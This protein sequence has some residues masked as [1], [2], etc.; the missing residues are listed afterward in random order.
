MID[1]TVFELA[2]GE[3]L[4]VGADVDDARLLPAELG[5]PGEVL[6]AGVEGVGWEAPS[7]GGGGGWQAMPPYINI[8]VI[9]ESFAGTAALLMS[10][11]NP[12]P[13]DA[14]YHAAVMDNTATEDMVVL[15]SA[16]PGN[17]MVLDPA[18]QPRVDDVFF[19]RIAT[20]DGANAPQFRMYYIGNDQ[21]LRG[22]HFL[23]L[24]GEPVRCD[25]NDA[26]VTLWAQNRALISATGVMIRVAQSADDNDAWVDFLLDGGASAVLDNIAV[27]GVPGPTAVPAGFSRLRNFGTPG[28]QDWRWIIGGPS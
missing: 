23:P 24:R 9:T 19:S 16:G 1:M 20:Y 10:A 2:G 26:T 22:P 4:S 18:I 15:T 3:M 11:A 7:G 27:D 12:L 8:A 25:T 13:F 6:T 17:A 14:G 5:E 28:D 21:G